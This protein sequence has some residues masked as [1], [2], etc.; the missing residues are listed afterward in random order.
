[1][2]SSHKR[3]MLLE[4]DT[5]GSRLPLINSL[6]R[7]AWLAR[8]QREEREQHGGG[9]DKF[10]PDQYGGIDAAGKAIPATEKIEDKA[11][12]GVVQLQVMNGNDP[13]PANR[14]IVVAGQTVSVKGGSLRILDKGVI[15]GMIGKGSERR[16]YV[17]AIV[18]AILEG[19]TEYGDEIARY[20]LSS[21]EFEVLKKDGD[22][23]A[24]GSAREI[25]KTEPGLPSIF[26]TYPPS[27]KEF[28]KGL[29]KLRLVVMNGSSFFDEP[30]DD[31]KK[32]YA[33]E[34]RDLTRA[35]AF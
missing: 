29:Q 25:L 34:M 6:R 26:L 10:F 17:D 33:G 27:S 23:A 5:K 14:D 20:V 22:S 30:L 13:D 19:G 24:L 4:G 18:G 7:G 35:E 12:A 2:L 9:A 1:M 32:K 31:W 16:Q 15:D 3:K 28:Q 11:Q 21:T 8:K